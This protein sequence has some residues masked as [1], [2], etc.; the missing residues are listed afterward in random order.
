MRP[1]KFDPLS[2]G[3]RRM[4]LELEWGKIVLALK[5]G[6]VEFTNLDDLVD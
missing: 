5:G 3:V 4:R 1:D 2:R 6:R